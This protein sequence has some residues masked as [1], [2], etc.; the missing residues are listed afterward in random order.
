[1]SSKLS[2]RGLISY[3]AVQH[4]LDTTTAEGVVNCVIDLM[5]ASLK[6]GE[7]VNIKGFGTFQSKRVAPRSLTGLGKKFKVGDRN[8]IRFVISKGFKEELN[9]IKIQGKADIA[10]QFKNLNTDED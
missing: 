8:K 1:M 2:K 5:K 10:N 4:G 6:R 9:G 3:V 7:S